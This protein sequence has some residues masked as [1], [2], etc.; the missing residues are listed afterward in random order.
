MNTDQRRIRRAALVALAVAA[1]GL[2][3]AADA[4]PSGA[5]RATFAGGCFWCMEEPFEKLPGVLSVT[6]GFAG[7]SKADPTD[8]E[9]SSGASGHAESVEIVYDPSRI[10]YERLL[11]VFWHNVDPLTP[12][13]QFCDRGRQYRTAIFFYD[14]GQRRLAEESKRRVEEE[15]HAAVVTEIAP[16]SKFYRAEEYHQ[17]FYKKNPIRYQ[18]YAKGCGRDRRLQQLWGSAAGHEQEKP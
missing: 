7:G 16:V 3:V 14:E 11:D 9:L 1:A 10:T 6:A 8:K 15:L 5:A 18:E 13:G 4:Q 17:D 2:A 12:N